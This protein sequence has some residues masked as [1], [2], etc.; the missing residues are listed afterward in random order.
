MPK[1]NGAEST[2][3]DKRQKSSPRVTR[4]RLATRAKLLEAAYNVMSEKGIDNAAVQEITDEADVGFGT[5]YNYFSSKDDLAA[6]VLDCVIHDLGGRNDIATAGLK[7]RNPSLVMPTS[8]RLVVREAHQDPIWRWWV[9]RPDLLVDRMRAGFGSFAFRDMKNATENN[10]YSVVGNDFK[11]TWDTAVWM[12]VGC[13]R[14]IVTGDCSYE[15]KNL[16]IEAILRV[17]GVP[18]EE[19]RAL[20]IYPLPEYPKSKIDFSFSLED[21][22][23]AA[24]II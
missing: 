1:M 11:A 3:D 13:M 15:H 7:E 6:E 24:A 9:L 8:M 18:A 22:I 16:A 2:P 17:T 10:G 4:R 19:C 23:Q 12:L 20:S 21:A 14:D 5:F